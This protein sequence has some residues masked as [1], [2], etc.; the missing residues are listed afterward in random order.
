MCGREREKI[1]LLRVESFDAIFA[2]EVFE[3]PM[4][5]AFVLH[6]QPRGEIQERVCHCGGSHAATSTREEVGKRVGH[7]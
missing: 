5:M 4:L 3:G 1:F 7:F 6:L 2:Q